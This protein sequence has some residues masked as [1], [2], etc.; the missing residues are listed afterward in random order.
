MNTKTAKFSCVHLSWADR[1]ALVDHY[2]PTDSAIMS[3]FNLT[4]D[5]LTTARQLRASGTFSASKTLDC[6]SYAGIFADSASTVATPV[7]NAQPNPA[8]KGG[9]T[10]HAKPESAAK[11]VKTPQKRGRKGDKITSALMSATATPVPVSDFMKQHNV[12][13]AVLRQAKRFI[14]KMDADTQAKIGKVVVKQDKT[15]KQLMIWKAND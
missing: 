1:F 9:S 10:T 8:V 7:V 3:T 6:A 14:E 2:A 12:S 13:L 15:T 4:N 11:R 5:E